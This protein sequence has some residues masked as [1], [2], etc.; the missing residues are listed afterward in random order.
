MY[1]DMV[2]MYPIFPSIDDQNIS[3]YP[4][5]DTLDQVFCRF[6]LSFRDVKSKCCTSHFWTGSK[7]NTTTQKHHILYMTYAVHVSAGTPIRDQKH[8]L[9]SQYKIRS[10]CKL[11]LNLVSHLVIFW[12]PSTLHKICSVHPS[13]IHSHCLLA[14]VFPLRFQHGCFFCLLLV[15]YVFIEKKQKESLHNLASQ[16]H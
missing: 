12:L 3:Y 6:L 7:I 10:T 14:S 11:K 2:W 8:P 5:R 15:F 9:T 13:S 1:S 16:L 4:A